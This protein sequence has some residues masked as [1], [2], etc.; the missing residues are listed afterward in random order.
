MGS[1]IH[2]KWER[3]L[4]ITVIKF[5][6]LQG[7]CLPQGYYS[8]DISNSQFSEKLN[9]ITNYISSP[10]AK[11]DQSESGIWI[12]VLCSVSNYAQKYFLKGNGPSITA[13]IISEDLY[14]SDLTN[15]GQP[16]KNKYPYHYFM[17]EVE[18]SVSQTSKLYIEGLANDKRIYIRDLFLFND[19]IPELYAEAFK[20]TDLSIIEATK[21][22][23]SMIFVCNFADFN[24][25]KMMS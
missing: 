9:K 6:Q 21:M 22:L 13:K 4:Q 12:W 14:Y 25:N 15:E 3:H 8:D 1:G 24:L 20:H 23:Q 2:F 19:Y 10:L 18:N 17:S 7:Y 5:T 16:V 11:E